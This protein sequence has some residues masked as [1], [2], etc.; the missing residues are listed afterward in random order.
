MT[1]S[2]RNFL[3]LLYI[4]RRL[5]FYKIFS[6]DGF[7]VPGIKVKILLFILSPINFLKKKPND[8]GNSLRLFI[9]ETGPI[10][11]KFGQMLSTRPDFVGEFIAKELVKLQDK[12]EIFSYEIT[13]EVFQKDFGFPPESKFKINPVPIA[14][15]SVAQVYRWQNDKNIS[16]AVKVLRPYVR[17]RY[18]KDIEFL[19]FLSSIA[20]KLTLFK[21]LNPTKLVEIF[22]KM[23]K[24]ELNMKIEAS[25]ADELRTNMKNDDIIIPKIYWEYVSENILVMEWI[26]GTP[27]YNIQKLFEYGLDL[28]SITKKIAIMFFNQA[29][30][31]GFFHADLHHGNILVTKSGKIALI[32]FGIVARLS[33][34]DRIMVAEM[35]FCFLNQNYKRITE[36]H[37]EGKIISEEIDIDLFTSYCR[38]IGES[39][40]GINI[41]KISLAKLLGDLLKIV[42]EFQV[43]TQPQ[44]FFLQKTMLTV[45]GISSSLNK[46]SNIWKLIEPWITK[47]AV[48][49]ISPEAKLLRYIKKIAKESLNIIKT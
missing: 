28:D 26:E 48:K 6:L 44:L 24:K 2:I 41:N 18:K 20:K 27:I 49:N 37:I 39:L 46:E 7:Y 25:S 17:Q 22:E 11:I 35:L 3:T 5:V 4:L 31:D 30:R 40:V 34:K 23:M 13:K 42:N 45:E 32:D 8:F 1:K 36:L 21:N 29:F 38:I 16:V 33:E 12:L 9:A 47:W 19:Y 15:A 43:T 10:F 14:S